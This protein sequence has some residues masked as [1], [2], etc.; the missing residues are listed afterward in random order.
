[1][2]FAELKILHLAAVLLSV[3]GFLARGLLMW[4]QSPLNEALWVRRVPHLV[5]TLL[6]GSAVA[7]LWVSGR[8]PANEPWLEM[9]L[10]C[11]LAYIVLG[12]LALKRAPT[13][14]LRRLCFGLAVFMLT[15]I[16]VIARTR[17]PQGLLSWVWS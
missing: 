8:S 5:D 10:W 9:K 11:V 16:V 17:N 2:N 4:R 7:M 15:H 13:L 12:A 1:M 3:G 6:L 14:V